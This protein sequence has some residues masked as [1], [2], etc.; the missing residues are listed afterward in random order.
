MKFVNIFRLIGRCFFTLLMSGVFRINVYTCGLSFIWTN[1]SL[2]NANDLN[3]SPNTLNNSNTYDM[4]I[5]F[6]GNQL[7]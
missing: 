5:K 6:P 1:N 2:N 3:N 7:V 4:A